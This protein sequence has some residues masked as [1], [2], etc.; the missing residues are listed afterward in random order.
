[1]KT[2]SAAS[3][4]HHL[5]T[6]PLR[7]LTLSLD[8]WFLLW[9]RRNEI[10]K[11][12]VAGSRNV[13]TE[14]LH[15]KCRRA[16]TR[17]LVRRIS[18]DENLGLSVSIGDAAVHAASLLLVKVFFSRRTSQNLRSS[19]LQ[20]R[21]PS[22]RKTSSWHRKM[23]VEKQP[24]A[25]QVRYTILHSVILSQFIHNLAIPRISV[26]L[27]YNADTK[28]SSRESETFS[29]LVSTIKTVRELFSFYIYHN[30]CVIQNIAFPFPVSGHS[31]ST[32]PGVSFVYRG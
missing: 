25:H 10:L 20:P 31:S 12:G 26:T 24:V 18:R 32:Y 4:R 23:L 13:K 28:V 14:I 11:R 17:E 3:S 27:Q 22:D 6:C 29:S 2:C 19:K 30:L 7:V 5:A 21:I 1:M 15:R 9:R 8:Q 16:V